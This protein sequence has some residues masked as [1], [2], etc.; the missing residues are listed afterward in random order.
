MICEN[1][2]CIYNDGFDCTLKSIELNNM[3]ICTSCI[4]I[5]LDKDILEAYKQQQLKKVSEEYKCNDIKNGA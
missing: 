1:E 3:G 4:M 2:Y 5:T